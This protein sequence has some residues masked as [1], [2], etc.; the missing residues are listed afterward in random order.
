MKGRRATAAWWRAVLTAAWPCVLGGLLGALWSAPAHAHLMVAQKGTLNIVGDGAYLVASL[1][2]SALV[3]VDDDKD[4]LL[5][6]AEMRA[7]GADIERQVRAGIRLSDPGGARP[8]EGLMLNLAQRDDAPT[9]PVSHLIV[10]GRYALAD[11]A[12]PLRFRHA[13]FGRA[14]AERRM[15]FTVIRGPERQRLTLAPDRDELALLSPLWSIFLDHSRLGAEHVLGGIDHLLFLLVVLST[16]SGLRRTVLALSCFTA[17][18]ATTLMASVLGGFSLPATI[19][20]PAI[21]VTIVGMAGFDRWSAGRVLPVAWR[22]GLVYLCAL[23]HG[24]G[25]AEALRDLDPGHRM[26]SLAGFNLGV[27]G[28]QVAVAVVLAVAVAAVRRLRWV[29]A[30]APVGRAGT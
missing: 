3:G 8:L 15:E 29:S 28:A 21:A 19:V 16:G 27:E 7:H 12:L 24:L 13:L 5:S 9:A 11:P 10:L 2:V 23:I 6:L 26:L 4:G 14:D 30:S 18:H 20:E 17:G 1:P 25:L 22:L